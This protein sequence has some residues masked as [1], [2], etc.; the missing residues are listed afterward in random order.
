MTYIIYINIAVENDSNCFDYRA[1]GNYK[2]GL[3][4]VSFNINIFNKLECI[5]TPVEIE[6]IIKK[7]TILNFLRA[8]NFEE[9]AIKAKVGKRVIKW[10]TISSLP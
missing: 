8:E 5:I 2:G 4:N 10:K 6:P 9:Q 7:R 1:A 3:Y